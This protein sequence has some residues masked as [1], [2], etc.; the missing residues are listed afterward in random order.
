M[1]IGEIMPGK[2]IEDYFEN[3][4]II[5]LKKPKTQL[6][7]VLYYLLEGIA[8]TRTHFVNMGVLNPTARM[9]TLRHKYGIIIDAPPIEV[10]NKHNRKIKFADWKIINRKHAIE[11][12]EKLTEK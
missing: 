5:K 11:V 3:S 6:Q 1:N 9:A 2:Q 12:Y 10:T 8:T 7:E 4:K